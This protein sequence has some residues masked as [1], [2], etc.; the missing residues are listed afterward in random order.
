[1]IS[2]YLGITAIS[3]KDLH[4]LNE[5]LEMNQLGFYQPK[6]H[7]EILSIEK[8]ILLSEGYSFSYNEKMMSMIEEAPFPN[9]LIMNHALAHRSFYPYEFEYLLNMTEYQYWKKDRNSSIPYP[10][11]LIFQNGKDLHGKKGNSFY[12]N[13]IR[14][15]STILHH[16]YVDEL[17]FL[18]LDEFLLSAGKFDNYTE[19]SDGWHTAGS[20]RQMEAVVLMNMLCNDWMSEGKHGS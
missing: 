3:E 1:M 2:H 5:H 13:T 20:V 8:P 12:S 11:Y 16:M 9:V 7:K 19:K 4:I 6:H 15:D 14:E 17:K 10:Q 18:V